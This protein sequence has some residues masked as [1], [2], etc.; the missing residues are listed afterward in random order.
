MNIIELFEKLHLDRQKITSLTPEEIIRIEKQLNAEKKIDEEIDTNTANNLIEALRNYAAPF[1]FIAGK[2][3]L[4]NLFSKKDYTRN[5]FVYETAAV[6]PDQVKVFMS[7]FLEEDLLL[8][9]DRYLSKNRYAEVSNF[10]DWKDYIPEDIL[11]RIKR[12]LLGKM[13]YVLTVLNT[14]PVGY[15]QDIAYIG[16]GSFY[17]LLN[18]FSSIETDDKIRILLNLI[19]DSYN[20]TKS[21]F[22]GTVLLSMATY[23]AFD[24]T[25]TAVMQKNRA[26]V[27]TPKSSGSSFSWFPVRLAVFV[28]IAFLKLILFTSKCS[29]N[30]PT[31][32]SSPF[33]F[34]TAVGNINA[35]QEQDAIAQQQQVGYYYNYLTNYDKS[36]AKDSISYMGVKTGENPFTGLYY[37][38]ITNLNQDD[39]AIK[40]TNRSGYDVVVLQNKALHGGDAPYG[41]YFVKANESFILYVGPALYSYSFYFGNKMASFGHA[42]A[43]MRGDRLQELRF[44]QLPDNCRQMLDKKFK[45][46]ADVLISGKKN[47]KLVSEGLSC[48]NDSLQKDIGKYTF[49]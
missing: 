33:D 12:K 32:A 3:V 4:Y 30:E 28:V 49:K 45:V 29:S 5:S 18:H 40:F 9:S 19:V 43:Y 35:S 36:E 6:D 46:Q 20:A 39:D 14:M 31:V 11:F 24:D 16:Y 47:I 21:S 37:N 27:V 22:S 25:L 38:R 26:V 23:N 8:A 13:D 34:N 48:V 15:E 17:E 42:S 1:A 41:A 10:L 44:S 2:R 7:R